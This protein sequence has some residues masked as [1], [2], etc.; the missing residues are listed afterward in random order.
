MGSEQSHKTSPTIQNPQ[1]RGSKS[2]SVRAGDARTQQTRCSSS[3]LPQDSHVKS[4]PEA[5][6]VDEPNDP[7]LNTIIAAWS[8]LPKAIR[9]G[10]LAMVLAT[11]RHTSD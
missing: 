9:T 5:S 8:S 10:V 7:G 4:A 3:S 6:R 11:K 2:G 1:S